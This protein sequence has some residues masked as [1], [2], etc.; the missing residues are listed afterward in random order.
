MAALQI[1]IQ[2]IFVIDYKFCSNYESTRL[3]YAKTELLLE[4]S[5][6]YML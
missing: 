3:Y 1:L 4:I 2:K 6:L 5:N